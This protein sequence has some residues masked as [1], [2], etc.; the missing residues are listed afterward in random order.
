MSDIRIGAPALPEAT[1][2]DI[3]QRLERGRLV[4]VTPD[5]VDTSVTWIDV[6]D[7]G[8]KEAAKLSDVYER[9]AEEILAPL[10]DIDKMA[11][12]R[13]IARLAADL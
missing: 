6:T 12:R 9:T 3:A 10:T 1:I 2:A 7:R 11:L 5:L 4:T 8:R 13:I